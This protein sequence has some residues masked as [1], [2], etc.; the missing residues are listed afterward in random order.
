MYF[1]E[2]MTSVKVGTH[3]IANQ[4]GGIRGN[5]VMPL[6]LPLNERLFKLAVGR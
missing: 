2:A 3:S 4:E 6:D 5:G 1:R